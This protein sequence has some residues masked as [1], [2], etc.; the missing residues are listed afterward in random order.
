[1]PLRNTFR[2][3]PA[4]RRVY[5]LGID[6]KPVNRNYG[7]YRFTSIYLSVVLKLSPGSNG[8]DN[9]PN[10]Q[11]RKVEQLLPTD[12]SPSEQTRPLVLDRRKRI[13]QA[14]DHHSRVKELEALAQSLLQ[15]NE[16][17]NHELSRE[18]HDN[19]AQVLAATTARISLA[20]EEVIPAWLRQELHDLCEHLRRAMHDVRVLARDLRPALLDHDGFVATLNHHV[21]NFRHR[22]PIRLESQ[23]HAPALQSFE[24]GHLNHF[25]RLIQEALHNIEEHSRADHAWIKL[26]TKEGKL[27]LEIGDNG[28]GFVPERVIKSQADGHLGLL[29]MRER[30]ELLGG[31]FIL[32][33]QPERG[34]TICIT[35]P[36]TNNPPEFMI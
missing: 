1:M 15:S 18:L 27:Y 12:R 3:T 36:N 26:L 9:T 28:C 13:P 31:H 6:S 19:I 33:S 34:T 24:N 30:A 23:I 20:E 16:K 4:V 10:G 35:I 25:F 21:E 14:V 29:G 2:T 17:Q 8:S 7:E 11:G 22:T 32:E 5:Q